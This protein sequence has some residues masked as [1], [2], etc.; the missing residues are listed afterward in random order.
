MLQNNLIINSTACTITLSSTDIKY[1]DVICTVQSLFIQ[2]L[3][4]SW[5]M[6]IKKN[7]RRV[8]FLLYS[9][10][11]FPSTLYHWF[12]CTYLING[13]FFSFLYGKLRTVC[14]YLCRDCGKYVESRLIVYLYQTNI[15]TFFK[16]TVAQDIQLRFFHEGAELP[17]PLNHNLNFSFLVSNSRHNQNLK[18]ESK[19]NFKLESFPSWFR[20]YWIPKSLHT[21]CCDFY[22]IDPSRASYSFL[23]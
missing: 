1:K 6:L 12:R 3:C 4:I 16:G 2:D 18:F 10:F 5:Q 22:M 15:E 8:F 7:L 20:R 13:I 19:R 11:I 17:I 21:V 23:T 9:K 14:I